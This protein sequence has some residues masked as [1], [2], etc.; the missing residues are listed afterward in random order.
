MAELSILHITLHNAD[1]CL[2][3]GEI[4]V[5]NLVEDHSF[6]RAKQPSIPGVQVYEQSAL[7][8]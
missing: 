2:W 1:H 5:R 6:T 8:A 7:E 4:G 3:I